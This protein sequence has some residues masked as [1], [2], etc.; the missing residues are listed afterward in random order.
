MDSFDNIYFKLFI[1]LTYNFFFVF[2]IL[3]KFIWIF[4][5]FDFL[6]AYHDL[7]VTIVVTIFLFYRRKINHVPVHENLFYG[8]LQNKTLI[9]DDQIDIQNQPIPLVIFVPFGKKR[10]KKKKKKKRKK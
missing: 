3:P 6:M 2:F 10:R 7:L 5:N 1:D 4:L 9:Y 8:L